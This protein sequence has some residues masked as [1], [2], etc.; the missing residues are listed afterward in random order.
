MRLCTLMKFCG[1]GLAATS[2]LQ[3]ASK[4]PNVLFILN[5]DQVLKH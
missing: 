4:R 1:M 3:A 2:A 5:D